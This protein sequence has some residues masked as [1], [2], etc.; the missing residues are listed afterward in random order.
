MKKKILFIITLVLMSFCIVNATEERTVLGLTSNSNDIV[1]GTDFNVGNDVNITK[2]IN[3]INVA[4]GNSL[5]INGNSE[6]GVIL[7]NAITINSNIDKELFVAGNNIVISSHIGRDSYIA[8][9]SVSLS[10]HFGRKVYVACENISLNDVNIHGD[11]RIISKNIT[12]GDNVNIN[13]KLTYDDNAV[14]T[15]IDKAN[16]L[17][18][19]KNH[20]ESND[21]SYDVINTKYTFESFLVSLIGLLIV[22]YAINLA[23]PKIYNN[24]DKKLEFKK[25]V[26]NSLAGLV[27][28]VILPISGLIVLFTGIGTPLG[29]II[30]LLYGI[31]CYV[32]KLTVLSIIGSKLYEICFKKKD[33]VYLSILIGIVVYKVLKLIPVIG[34]LVTFLALIAGLGYVVML[35]FKKK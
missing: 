10:G 23:F 20:V 18:V 30:L 35:L 11:V 16:I 22:A 28:L 25:F 33:N 7:G 31:L 14:V 4:A 27:V 12:F 24:L 32:A 3:G 19:V 2:R 9:S 8:G 26:N 34:G 21:E 29:I 17:E 1:D 5:N 15:G 13:G 6:Y